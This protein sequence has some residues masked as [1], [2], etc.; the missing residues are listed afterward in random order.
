[1]F[2]HMVIN[3]YYYYIPQISSLLTIYW[4]Y[5]FICLT[6]TNNN[7]PNINYLL[8]SLVI[9][10][11]NIYIFGLL[12]SIFINFV[13]FIIILYNNN[14]CNKLNIFDRILIFCLFCLSFTVL[15]LEVKFCNN[16]IVFPW[17]ILF[18]ILFW[19]INSNLILFSLKYVCMF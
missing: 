8:F 11:I 13:I 2:G 16:S 6:T 1:M 17:H 12:Y 7:L 9:G 18:D 4:I 3:P 19:Q 10:Y 5:K 14:Y 15:G